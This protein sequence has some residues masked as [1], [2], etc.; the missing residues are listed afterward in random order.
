MYI[1]TS[2]L[3]LMLVLAPTVSV[4][5]VYAYSASEEDNGSGGVFDPDESCLFDVEQP[6]CQLPE[7]MDDCPE[8]FGTN[9]DRQCF[10]LDENGNW[11]CPEGYHNMDDDETGQCY[12]NDEECPPGMIFEEGTGGDDSD[13]CREMTYLCDEE[14]H[15]KEDYCIEFCQERQDAEHI[16]FCRQVLSR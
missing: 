6:K 15:M 7:D 12:S 3:V 11:T 5:G 9:E 13:S 10:P 16:T 1:Q 2:I 8:G 4:S 14:E